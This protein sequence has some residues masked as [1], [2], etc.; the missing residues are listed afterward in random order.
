MT[1]R[2]VLVIDDDRDFADGLAE[3]LEII[4]HEAATAYTPSG[5][6]AA[7]GDGRYD[8]AMIDIGL[9]GCNGADCAL[10]IQAQRSD[11]TCILMTGYSGDTL[12][13][14]GIKLGDTMMLRKP[15]RPEDLYACLDD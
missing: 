12:D 1:A 3:L 8:V 10:Q 4:G 5:G 14:M 6:V 9:P 13:R 11:I 2:R 15:I 7:A